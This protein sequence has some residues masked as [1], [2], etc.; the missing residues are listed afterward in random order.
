MHKRMGTAFREASCWFPPRAPEGRINREFASILL[1]SRWGMVLSFH[2]DPSEFRKQRM[3]RATIPPAEFLKQIHSLVIDFFSPLSRQL[4]KRL[5]RS[6]LAACRKAFVFEPGVAEH[7]KTTWRVQLE[8]RGGGVETSP[9]PPPSKPWDASRQPLLRPLVSPHRLHAWLVLKTLS[10]RWPWPRRS[11][12]SS[13]CTRTRPRRG[14]RT[15][16]SSSRARS[17]R[18]PCVAPPPPLPAS[19]LAFLEQPVGTV[20]AAVIVWL[21][22]SLES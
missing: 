3:K 20:H 1:L 2:V 7:S 16:R 14:C 8:T 13:P 11:A 4:P 22:N 17:F 15:R 5:T 21:C 19:P 18:R 6:L 10:T 9:P 12:S